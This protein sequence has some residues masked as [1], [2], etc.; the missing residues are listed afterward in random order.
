MDTLTLMACG[1][2]VTATSLV[3]GLVLSG[4][5]NATLLGWP[6]WVCAAVIALLPLITPLFNKIH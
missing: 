1:I 6:C 5:L 2:L 3:L 4:R